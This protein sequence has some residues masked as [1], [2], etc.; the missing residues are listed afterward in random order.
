MNTA[1]DALPDQQAWT[2]NLSQ[3]ASQL[4]ALN[5]MLDPFGIGGSFARVSEGWTSRPGELLAGLSQLAQ[6]LQSVQLNVWQTAVGL[7]AL[8]P[9]VAA[10]DDERFA[11]AAWNEV[12]ALAMLK[13]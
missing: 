12:P 10:K 6:Q 3:C 11:D 5:K 4:A 2:A 8:A 9:V 13:Q 1:H 7:P